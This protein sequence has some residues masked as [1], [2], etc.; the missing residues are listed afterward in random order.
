ML[1]TM[2]IPLLIEQLLQMVVG[3]ADTM[4]YT[5]FIYLFTSCFPQRYSPSPCRCHRGSEPDRISG[6]STAGSGETDR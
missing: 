3:L 5:I 1:K 4:I 6:A 2:I